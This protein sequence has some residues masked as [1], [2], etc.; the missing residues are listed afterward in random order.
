MVTT[1]R[2][3]HSHQTFSLSVRGMPETHSE[4]VDVLAASVQKSSRTIFVKKNRGYA[5]HHLHQTRP[6]VSRPFVDTI[7]TAFLRSALMKQQ[8]APL[9]FSKNAQFAMWTIH[10]RQHQTRPPCPKLLVDA[11]TTAFLRSADDTTSRT[12]CSFQT[13][14]D[15]DA[16]TNTP[17]FVMS[18]THERHHRHCASPR[19]FP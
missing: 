17:Q 5:P 11:I 3:F 6:T 7:P 13:S 12:L 18:T 4:D 15:A 9:S 14:E 1:L 2:A 19:R 8:H 10:E 16:A